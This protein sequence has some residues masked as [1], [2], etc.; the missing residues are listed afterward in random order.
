[1]AQEYAAGLHVPDAVSTGDAAQFI[2]WK[3]SGLI[4][5]YVPEDVAK[6]IP[7]N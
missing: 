1:V 6:H 3:R 4:A 2:A 5:A 7:A